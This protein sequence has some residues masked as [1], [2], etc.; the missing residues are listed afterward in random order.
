ML[1]EGTQVPEDNQ[2]AAQFYRLA[3]ERG[4]VDAMV[5]LGLMLEN[6]EGMQADPVAATAMFKKAAEKGDAF[7]VAKIAKPGIDTAT[8]ASIE[9]SEQAN[10]VLTKS[11][12]AK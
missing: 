11:G 8:T 1:D 9:P 3:A 5:N 12:R 2:K 10:L 6:G 4:N 7:A